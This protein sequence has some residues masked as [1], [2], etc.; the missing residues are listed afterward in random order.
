MKILE[1]F[2]G[3]Q[4]AATIGIFSAFMELLPLHRS[5]AHGITRRTYCPQYFLDCADCC[6]YLDCYYTGHGNNFLVPMI[7]ERVVGLSSV[8]VLLVLMVGGALGFAAGGVAVA[9]L[10]M[11][12]S[13]PIAASIAIFVQD[14]VDK[15]K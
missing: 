1:Y 14:Y 2:F 8:V 4:Y 7:M 9:I 11:I 6:D 3:M 12:F 15:K 10:G 13:V 5:L